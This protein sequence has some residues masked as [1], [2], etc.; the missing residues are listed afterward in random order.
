MAT[1]MIRKYY[2]YKSDEV[3]NNVNDILL[4]VLD[5]GFLV[6]VK[7][8]IKNGV[9]GIIID[10]DSL[11][12]NK[13][14][15]DYI[16]EYILRINDYLLSVGYIIFPYYDSTDYLHHRKSTSHSKRGRLGMEISF[17]YN[18]K[19]ILYHSLDRF[20]HSSKT[21]NYNLIKMKYIKELA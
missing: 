1:R 20:I 16:S 17:S 18:T 11:P 15:G 21:N 6:I 5:D 3:V 12:P 19:K 14:P 13:I 4:E 8:F 10:I 7:N 2:E 9:E